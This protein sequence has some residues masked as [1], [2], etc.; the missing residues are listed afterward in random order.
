MR[1]TLLFRWPLTESA[2]PGEAFRSL[3]ALW[4][5]ARV[6]SIAALSA[7]TGHFQLNGFAD[8][9]FAI[10][11]IS[12]DLALEGVVSTERAPSYF[13]TF[14]IFGELP[15]ELGR[16]QLTITR[17]V[18]AV[19]NLGERLVLHPER[20][21]TGTLAIR[22]GRQFVN[23]EL[24][25]LLGQEPATDPRF[26]AALDLTRSGTS[27]MRAVLRDVLAQLNGKHHLL[28]QPAM[29]RAAVR[30]RHGSAAR[31]SAHSHR[32]AQGR[33]S[34]AAVA[35]PCSRGRVHRGP[36]RRADHPGGHRPGGGTQRPDGRRGVS[37]PPRCV[38]DDARP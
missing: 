23:R 22:L 19:V 9:E 18:A 28:A 3:N 31:P 25:V 5:P 6:S 12:T 37:P 13:L 34:A 27:G 7:D 17:S 38:P 30:S 14:G 32:V 24:T 10:G 4:A 33:D 1:S 8:D 11:F 16:R 21:P 26:E 29:R 15:L 2:E 20:R 35:P 36:P